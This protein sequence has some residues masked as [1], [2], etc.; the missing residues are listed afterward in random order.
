MQFGKLNYVI[1]NVK[2]MW[3]AQK[4]W[5]PLIIELVAV[6]GNDACDHHQNDC[7]KG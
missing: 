6:K 7:Q 3:N 4:P 2:K 1:F 5:F